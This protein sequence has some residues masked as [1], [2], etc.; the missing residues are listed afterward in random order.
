MVMDQWT[1]PNQLWYPIVENGVQSWVPVP[2][3][4][5]VPIT[6]RIRS[7]IPAG[8]TIRTAGSLPPTG[9]PGPS[10]PSPGGP[11]GPPPS[12]VGPEAGRQSA[13]ARAKASQL[14]YGAMRGLP[15]MSQGYLGALQAGQTPAP[16][17]MTPQT[18][19]ALAG[20]QF[21]SDNFFALL[22]AAGLYPTSFLSEVG[23]FQ[24]RGQDVA[25]SFI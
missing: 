16:R 9:G 11:G 3:G 24:P 21:L 20:D 17:T 10:P 6:A 13:S 15:F 4:A 23:R 7:Q 14:L 18:L 22:E 12:G 2:P 8:Q 1:D 19:A 5:P 25:P